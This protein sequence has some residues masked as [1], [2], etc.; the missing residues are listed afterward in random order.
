MRR[1]M[2]GWSGIRLSAAFLFL[3]IAVS[4]NPISAVAAP[5]AGQIL[6]PYIA[7]HADDLVLWQPWSQSSLQLAQR[8]NKLLLVSSGY[9]ACRYCYVMKNESFEN[10]EIAAYI[11]KH[12]IPI[13][14]DSEMDPVLDAQLQRFMEAMEQPQGWPLQVILTPNRDP[15]IGV[16][17]QPPE[18]FLSFLQRV[19]ARW[20][21]SPGR[22][23]EIAQNATKAIVRELSTQAFEISDSLKIQFVNGLRQQALLV[24]DED[25]GGFGDDAKYPMSPQTLALIELHSLESSRAL[26]RILVRSLDA[27]ATGGLYD[28]VNGGFFRYT[29]TRDWR[30]PHYEKMLDTNAQ[31]A[32]LY[33]Q[34]ARHLDRPEYL[35]VTKN[36]LDMLLQD[37]SLPGGGLANSLAA[38]DSTGRDGGAYLW[39]ESTLQKYL[40]ADQLRLAKSNWHAVESTNETRYLPVAGS[41]D[42][43]D[44]ASDSSSGWRNTFTR[45]RSVR[46]KDSPAKD[47]KIVAAGHG[48]VLK[49]FSNYA[50]MDPDPIYLGAATRLFNLVKSDLWS[51]QYL[52]HSNLGGEANL[53]DYAYLA[54]GCLVFSQLS[55]NSEALRMSINL[56][57]IAWQKFYIDGFWRQME[58]LEQ[59]MPYTVY[60]V[61]LQDTQLPSASATLAR[62]TLSL[63]KK[64]LPVEFGL[65]TRA[66]RIADANMAES[67]FFYATQILSLAHKNET[68]KTN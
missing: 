40:Q 21:E 11:N 18:T 35:A 1:F 28:V 12:F 5:G 26:R 66:Q 31:L 57:R 38:V 14:I 22:M 37:F 32:N 46:E 45:L 29:T 51:G 6:S 68:A 44:P 16:V 4:F 8:E 50:A 30:N 7:S 24:A 15:L 20:Q 43:L 19:Q 59:L 49:A 53:A 9:L 33:L 48:L 13:L 17:Y 39:K 58:Q 64:T 36:T 42:N 65:A 67:P 3:F 27:M 55:G 25:N 47:E 63:G 60:P 62:V 34:A 61:T 41:L 52:K 54:E 2:S 56:T 10:R 23:A